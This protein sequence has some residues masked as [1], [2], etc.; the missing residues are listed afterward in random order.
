MNWY[1]KSTTSLFDT[2]NIPKNPQSPGPGMK[3]QQLYNYIKS[4]NLQIQTYH[5]TTMANLKL[6][7]KD[8][9][10]L[11]GGRVGKNLRGSKKDFIYVSTSKAIASKYA[12][13]FAG[14]AQ[15]KENV[16]QDELT[17]VVA[18]ILIPLYAISELRGVIFG[19]TSGQNENL[20][21][22]DL[23]VFM[24][25]TL[26][27]NEKTKAVQKIY[28]ELSKQEELTVYLGIPLKWMNGQ[29]EI[30]KQFQ[31]LWN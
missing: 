8:G 7:Q 1:K 16:S 22:D 6:A 26:N 2:Q 31:P 14:N 17:A 30:V 10:L 18:P 20:F 9:Y 23:K 3:A 27:Q 11:H 19:G 28:A 12:V 24:E 21:D 5:G 15:T 25:T 29:P 4:Q 13:K